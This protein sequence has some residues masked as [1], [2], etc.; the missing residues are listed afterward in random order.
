[1]PC[2]FN[3]SVRPSYREL[4]RLRKFGCI[5][6]YMVR[7]GVPHAD[8]DYKRA[9][10]T[11]FQDPRHNADVTQILMEQRRVSESGSMHQNGRATASLAVLH[12]FNWAEDRCDYRLCRSPTQSHIGG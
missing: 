2:E 5:P 4:L 3:L 6:E 12:A 9:I 8:D 11:A 7:Y 1:M 10:L